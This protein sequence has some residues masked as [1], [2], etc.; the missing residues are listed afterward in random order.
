MSTQNPEAN[1]QH[2][3]V[4]LLLPWYVNNS[5]QN[6]E[7]LLV[8]QHIRCCLLC[9]RELKGLVQ[10]SKAVKHPADMEMI[11]NAS[12]ADLKYK[13]PRH[14]KVMSASA[15]L[16]NPVADHSAGWLRRLQKTGTYKVVPGFSHAYL[17]IAATVL[18]AVI[19]LALYYPD[20][21]FATDYYTLA[22]AK[23]E[24]SAVGFQLRVVFSPA[25]PKQQIDA[26]LQQIHGRITDEP[27]SLGAY[28]VHLNQADSTDNSI[29]AALAFLRHQPD[30]VLVEP[31][32]QP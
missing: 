2:Q 4:S 26:L 14:P 23:P 19:P 6:D 7:R 9:R 25:L 15:E 16:S 17:A 31:V 22:A 30:V 13:L 20:A 12:F 11:A 8:E 10:L 3:D 21:K 27:N 18:M 5:L 29:A 28:T 24:V 32:L 1:P